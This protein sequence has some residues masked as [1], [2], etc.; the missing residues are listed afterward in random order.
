MTRE[1]L[2]SVFDMEGKFV[3][4][5]GSFGAL[6]S[7]DVSAIGSAAIMFLTITILCIKLYKALRDIEKPDA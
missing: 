6:V 7:W 5:F 4:G 1:L 3:T 2:S